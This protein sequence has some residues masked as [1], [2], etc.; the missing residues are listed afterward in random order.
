MWPLNSLIIVFVWVAVGRAYKTRM[1]GRAVRKAKTQETKYPQAA[2]T[3]YGV[4][5]GFSIH[6]SES[7]VI[8]NSADLVLFVH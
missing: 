7:Q 1:Q 5:S 4:S 2:A 3:N 8:E 6:E